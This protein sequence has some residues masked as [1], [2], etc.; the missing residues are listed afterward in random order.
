MTEDDLRQFTPPKAQ[1]HSYTRRIIYDMRR[2]GLDLFTLIADFPKTVKTVK[3][4]QINNKLFLE[5]INKHP[6]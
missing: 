5:N 4:I 3:D 2:Y 6:R 1:Y